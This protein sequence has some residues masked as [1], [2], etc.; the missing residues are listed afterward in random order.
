MEWEKGCEYMKQSETLIGVIFSVAI[1][2][3]KGKIQLDGIEHFGLI[4]HIDEHTKLIGAN[5]EALSFIEL[6]VGM[7]VKLTHSIAMT[8]SIPPQTYADQLTVI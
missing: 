4:V 5:G 6:Q 8:M 1:D 7:A 3:A 2:G